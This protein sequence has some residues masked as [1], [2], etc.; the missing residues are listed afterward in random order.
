MQLD[1]EDLANSIIGKIKNALFLLKQS[2]KS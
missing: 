2:L 1:S